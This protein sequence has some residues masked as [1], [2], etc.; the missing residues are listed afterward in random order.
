MRHQPARKRVGPLVQF[1]IR[2]VPI[3]IDEGNVAAPEGG[4]LLDHAMN[5]RVGHRPA[6][7]QGKGQGRLRN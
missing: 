5:S 7:V 6:E 2:D 3:A 4:V 1:P